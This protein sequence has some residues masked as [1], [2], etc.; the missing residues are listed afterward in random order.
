MVK[1]IYFLRSLDVL[2]IGIKIRPLLLTPK[3][4]RPLFSCFVGTVILLCLWDSKCVGLLLGNEIFILIF[5]CICQSE[6]KG[7]WPKNSVSIPF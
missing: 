6:G 4:I 7:Y 1:F 3:K 2:G 5:I